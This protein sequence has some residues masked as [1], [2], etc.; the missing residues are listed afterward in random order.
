MSPSHP[1]GNVAITLPRDEPFKRENRTLH[2]ASLVKLLRLITWNVM[3]TFS[4]G[5]R[6]RT[7]S[8][9]FGGRLL[10]QEHT[11]RRFSI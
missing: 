8:S 5:V 3:A 7:P 10:S 9:G 11:A 6:I 2:E 4:D 1:Q